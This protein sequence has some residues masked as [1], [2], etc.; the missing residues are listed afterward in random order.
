[1][2]TTITQVLLEGGVDA[3]IAEYVSNLFTQDPEGALGQAEDVLGPWIADGTSLSD[4]VE[5]LRLEIGKPTDRD[6]SSAAPGSGPASDSVQQ[7]KSPPPAPSGG[8]IEVRTEVDDELK[9]TFLKASVAGDVA[10]VKQMLSGDTECAVCLLAAEDKYGETAFRLA[11]RWNRQ[12]LLRELLALP[13]ATATIDSHNNGYTALMIAASQG[14]TAIVKLLLNCEPPA[15]LSVANNENNTAFHLAARGGH[16]AVFNKL[17]DNL[18][19]CGLDR[20]QA[21]VLLNSVDSS[22]ETVLHMW[23]AHGNQKCVERL[24]KIK[25]VDPSMQ[26]RDGNTPMLAAALEKHE[27]VAVH[28]LQKGKGKGVE[29]QNSLGLSVLH[30]AA[31]NGLQKLAVC[32]IA[33]GAPLD[34]RNKEFLGSCMPLHIAASYG[35]EAIARFILARGADAATP[36]G[37]GHTSVQ[38]ARMAGHEQ[39]AEKLEAA[40]TTESTE[41]EQS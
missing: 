19:S 40:I 9:A 7:T 23:A 29:L 34:S 25:G 10:Q 32:A 5:K 2:A 1:M 36:N 33:V 17:V 24:M 18:N 3:N 12:E 21:V 13:A 26:D 16:V 28:I 22:A 8:G 4:L 27:D 31:S 39:L 11:V 41:P 15:S 37:D 20:A 6:G 30:V 14:F 38:L 35:K